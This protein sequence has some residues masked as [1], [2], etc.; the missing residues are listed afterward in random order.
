MLT[1]PRKGEVHGGSPAVREGEGTEVNDPLPRV[2]SPSR[3]RS[4]HADF[5]E[6]L[7]CR[8]NGAAPD[9]PTLASRGGVVHSRRVVREEGQRV[10]DRELRTSSPIPVVT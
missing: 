1:E 7:A 3:T 5:K 9:R 10:V 2:W 4:L 6:A 8:L